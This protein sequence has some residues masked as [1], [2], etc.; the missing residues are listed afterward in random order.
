[1]TLVEMPAVHTL[2]T[3]AQVDDQARDYIGAARA[4]NTL[5]GYRADWGH[6]SAWCA[7]QGLTALPATPQTVSRYLTTQAGQR[8]TGTLSRRLS[9]IAQAHKVAG[10]SSP[11][12]DATLRL[13]WAGIRRTHGTA[14]VGK[15]ATAVDELRR[16]VTTLPDSLLG[17]RDRALLLLG[18][19][20]AFRRSEL[21]ALDVA[22]VRST[23]DGLIVTVRRG[24]TDQEGT[25]RAIG[26]PYGS[27]PATCPVRA[28]AAW[29]LAA[30]I[31]VGPLLR[32]VNRHGHTHAGRMSDRS[33]ALIVKRAAA[34]AGLDPA[35]YAG[36]S[37]RAGLATAAAGAGVSERVIAQ[38]TGH[39]SMVVLRRYIRAGTLFA[40]GENAA[41]AIGL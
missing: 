10:H 28:V 25:G 41:A 12:Q 35:L 21:V 1:M 34:A 37:L 16:M 4:P 23:T 39:K 38:Q 24:K 20:G 11:T 31:Q 13:V 6:F 2:A 8:K 32:S 17:L 3:L 22:D 26:I 30:D 15:T 5:R 18:F 9:A 14:Q 19:A 29:R 7:T 36:H 33:V 27:T 40:P